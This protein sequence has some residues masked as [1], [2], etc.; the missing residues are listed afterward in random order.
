MN[1]NENDRFKYDQRQLWRNIVA[2]CYLLIHSIPIFL[3]ILLEIPFCYS[4][5]TFTIS[6]RDLTVICCVVLLAGRLFCAIR[7]D[8]M[9]SRQLHSQNN[10]K[11]FTIEMIN[12]VHCASVCAFV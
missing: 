2:E 7:I 5:G 10:K 9:D 8:E 6:S 3:Y 11:H 12:N 4:A 1:P